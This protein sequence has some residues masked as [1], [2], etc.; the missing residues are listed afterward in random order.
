MSKINEL[1][2]HS[3]KEIACSGSKRF[4]PIFFFFLKNTKLACEEQVQTPLQLMSQNNVYTVMY[5]QILVILSI[6][7]FFNAVTLKKH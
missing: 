6:K 5:N 2:P 3:K 4:Q 1:F 7:T